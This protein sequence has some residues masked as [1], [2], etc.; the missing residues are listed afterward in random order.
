MLDTAAAVGRVVAALGPTD[1]GSMRSETAEP[2]GRDAMSPEPRAEEAETVPQATW[3][4]DAAPV[5][6]PAPRFA[7]LSEVLE[8]GRAGREHAGQP[9][10]RAEPEGASAA[11]PGAPRDQRQAAATPAGQAGSVPPRIVVHYRQD[12][13]ADAARRIAAELRAQGYARTELRPVPFP[14][15]RANVRF[16]HGQNRS[17]ARA[18]NELVQATGRRSDLRDFTHYVPLPTL[19]TVE[20]WLP[21]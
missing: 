5:P 4:R 19:G 15:S 11:E 13:G 20:I 10:A 12:A 8:R 7:R 2:L 3:R 21:G 6:L 9:L 17:V 18:V 14:V 16:F 1:A